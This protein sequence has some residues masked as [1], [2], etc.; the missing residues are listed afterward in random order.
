MKRRFNAVE[1]WRKKALK[2][3]LSLREKNAGI[4]QCNIFKCLT[5]LMLVPK[6]G[7]RIQT[8]EKIDPS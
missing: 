2:V 4:L 1:A 5:S 7:G 3:T 8:T 6:A